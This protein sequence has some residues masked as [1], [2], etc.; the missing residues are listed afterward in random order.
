MAESDEK[1]VARW[2][3]VLLLVG[4][5][6]PMVAGVDIVVKCPQQPRVVGEQLVG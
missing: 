1:C 4:P 5:H 3:E 2:P 6:V